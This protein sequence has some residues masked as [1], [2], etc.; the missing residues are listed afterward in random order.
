MPVPTRA[1]YWSPARQLAREET[2]QTRLTG[3][4]NYFGK[5]FLRVVPQVRRCP[6]HPSQYGALLGQAF[7]VRVPEVIDVIDLWND[8]RRFVAAWRPPRLRTE[9]A[10]QAA[11]RVLAEWERLSGAPAHPRD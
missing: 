9:P 4:R 7:S 11:A 10:Q 3:A 5:V 6:E 2:N 8:I 1:A